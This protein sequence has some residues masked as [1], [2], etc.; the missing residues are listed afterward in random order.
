MKFLN[1][2]I[3]RFDAYKLDGVQVVADAKETLEN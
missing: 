3:A 2:N 1:I